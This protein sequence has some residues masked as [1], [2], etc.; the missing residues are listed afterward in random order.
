MADFT[1]FS[2]EGKTAVLIGGGGAIGL[3]AARLFLEA[4]Y[5]AI[6]LSRTPSPAIGIDN[7]LIDLSLEQAESKLDAL[8][9]KLL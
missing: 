6:N 7:H 2:L 4:G 8:F 5:H 9:N 1:Q 3:A